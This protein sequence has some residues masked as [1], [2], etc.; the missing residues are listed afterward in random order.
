[1][2]KKYSKCKF[3]CNVSGMICCQ[4]I[5]VTGHRRNSE[6]ENCDKFINGK[7]IELPTDNLQDFQAKMQRKLKK[8]A[9]NE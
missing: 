8:E 7:S 4:Y 9:T 5:L 6:L 2:A 1:M 3:R